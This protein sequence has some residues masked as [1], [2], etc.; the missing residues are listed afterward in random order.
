MSFPTSFL[1]HGLLL[2]ASVKGSLSDGKMDITVVWRQEQV[3]GATIR[4]LPA[5]GH[6]LEG[7]SPTVACWLELS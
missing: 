7:P 1:A 2:K 6:I 4:S 5:T 3:V